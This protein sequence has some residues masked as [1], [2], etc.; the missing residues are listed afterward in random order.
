MFLTMICDIKNSRHID[1]REF[2]QME[3]ISTLKKCNSIFEKYIVSPFII[4]LGDEW[5]GLLI[6]NTP[7]LDIIS[8][9]EQSLPQNIKFY[10][11]IG[12]GAITIHNF[13]LTVNQLDGPSFYLARKAI[14]YAKKNNCSLIIMKE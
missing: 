14:K 10:T 5:Q 4:T 8:F 2:V 7:Y 3:I 12:I 11:G 13:E 6:E 9:L 1:N